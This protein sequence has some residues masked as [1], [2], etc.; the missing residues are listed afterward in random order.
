MKKLIIT[1]IAALLALCLHAQEFTN[2]FTAY[3]QHN[4]IVTDDSLIYVGCSRGINIYYMDGSFKTTVGADGEV[5]SAVRDHDGNIWFGVFAYTHGTKGGGLI[6]YD[7]SSWE[8]I[9][10]NNNFVYTGI[11]SITCDRNNNIWASINPG[12]SQNLSKVSKFNGTNWIDYTSFSDTIE[13]NIAEEIV[14]DTNNTIFIGVSSNSIESYYNI[15]S[16]S[17]SDTVL[18]NNSNSGTTVLCKHSS[19]VDKQNRVWFGGCF[20]RINSFENGAWT[21]HDNNSVFNNK[22]FSVIFQDFQDRMI[23]ATESKLFTEGEIEWEVNTFLDEHSLSSVSD[24][25]SDS[26][27]KIWLVGNFDYGDAREGCLIKPV[28]DTFQ[29]LHPQSHIG[30][31]REIAFSGNNIWFGKNA[32]LS[33]FNG[34]IWNNI[35]TTQHL[36]SEITTAVC[37]DIDGTLCT[38]H[39]LHYINKLRGILPNKF[40]NFAERILLAYN[41]LLNITIAFG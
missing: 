6:K 18:Y 24:I 36:C 1:G 11:T 20:G 15:I 8:F 37:T 9:P 33:S 23:L 13:I 30:F 25:N 19:L 10:V 2:L 34:V 21:V 27:E 12:D 31:P 14:C 28:A 5:Y 32:Y 16:I 4:C 39:Q 41:V 29:F 3:R 17:E 7:G 35:F 40:F 26:E 38:G 22:S